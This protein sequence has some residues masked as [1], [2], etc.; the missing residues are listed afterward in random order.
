MVVIDAYKS[1]FID[2]DVLQVI[3]E[4]RDI[5][6]PEKNIKLVLS[7]FKEFYDIENTEHIMMMSADLIGTNENPL[8]TSGSQQTLIKDLTNKNK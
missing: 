4:F 8:R 7:G 1:K 2:H 3:K 5:K 6:A